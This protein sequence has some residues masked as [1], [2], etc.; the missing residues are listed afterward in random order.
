M[1]HCRK[2][3]LP[4]LFLALFV[5]KVV[6]GS[7]KKLQNLVKHD[8]HIAN[9]PEELVIDV[10][11]VTPEDFMKGLTKTVIDASSYNYI[12]DDHGQVN[13]A[14]WLIIGN[15]RLYIMPHAQ[16][17]VVKVTNYKITSTI[18]VSYDIGG[19]TILK[20][21]DEQLYSCLSQMFWS[22]MFRPRSYDGTKDLYDQDQVNWVDK[23]KTIMMWNTPELTIED[24]P[25]VPEVD[26]E[27]T[28][29]I[30][31]S[32]VA[33][34]YEH[35]RINETSAACAD[36]TNEDQ[37]WNGIFIHG[38]K[39]PISRYCDRFTV[40]YVN[41]SAKSTNLIVA[42]H[43]EYAWI[44][45]YYEVVNIGTN[46]IKLIPLENPDFFDDLD[47]LPSRVLPEK[48]AFIGQEIT[49]DVPDFNKDNPYIELHEEEGTEVYRYKEGVPSETA[50]YRISNVK[51]STINYS[52]PS[53]HQFVLLAFSR[54]YVTTHF[55]TLI[56]QKGFIFTVRKWYGPS[57][58]KMEHFPFS[59]PED[60]VDAVSKVKEFFKYK[61]E[62]KSLAKLSLGTYSKEGDIICLNG[63]RTPNFTM[64]DAKSICK[65]LDKLVYTQV[66][67]KTPVYTV[68]KIKFR[69]PPSFIVLG[70]TVIALGQEG[71]WPQ[72]MIYY[73][74]APN[75]R[76]SVTISNRVIGVKTALE[77]G[78][79]T[80]IFEEVKNNILNMPSES[81][82][83]DVNIAALNFD[84]DS[85]VVM[86]YRWL[87]NLWMIVPARHP[88]YSIGSV[89]YYGCKVVA[90]HNR[91]YSF[92]VLSSEKDPQSLV[93]FYPHV[94]KPYFALKLSKTSLADRF[95]CYVE[96]IKYKS[97]YI[98]MSEVRKRD[99][100]KIFNK[101]N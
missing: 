92:I 61:N 10:L 82:Q 44:E 3:T 80:M 2:I 39:V 8:L 91:G 6:L 54:P 26:V 93:V 70:G 60:V 73:N 51:F 95:T 17:V 18:S 23:I 52:I 74:H 46:H 24:D 35:R 58:E 69:A 81:T 83:V 4:L 9:I 33:D 47:E 87:D 32:K 29:N 14:I 101:K 98:G 97:D 48:K 56:T 53:D 27:L 57:R 88:E 72:T 15:Q 89:T 64:A 5:R 67:T 99:Y 66:I 38:V 1:A 78:I 85:G 7:P 50:E 59:N 22:R 16:N 28:E 90:P 77:T 42:S 34:S 13:S 76:L 96:P 75:S 55:A 100:N 11:N 43:I 31:T 65:P 63:V 21:Y 36:F 79:D 19:A 84:E 41:V 40:C 45:N 12:I 86:K 62:N 30:H 49:L 25:R 37:R 71:E 68:L 94:E 20:Q